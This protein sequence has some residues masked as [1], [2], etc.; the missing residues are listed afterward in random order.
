MGFFRDLFNVIYNNVDLI[1]IIFGLGIVG[2]IVIVK[3][4]NKKRE[5]DYYDA[6]NRYNQE[7]KIA[8]KRNNE[9]EKH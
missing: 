7:R 1:W 6:F 8:E 5:N 4:K 2:T 3:I 9:F